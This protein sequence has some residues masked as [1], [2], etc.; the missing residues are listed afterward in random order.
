MGNFRYFLSI[1]IYIERSIDRIG[2]QVT[3]TT[4]L[5]PMD[6]HEWPQRHAPT[7]L[8]AVWNNC[9]PVGQPYRLPHTE[10]LKHSIVFFVF[11]LFI[12]FLLVNYIF[13]HHILRIYHIL[14]KLCHFPHSHIPYFHVF[15]RKAGI[16]FK[17]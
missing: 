15:D 10:L 8:F 7:A 11:S 1:S 5:R 2:R 6:F 13:L 17:S 16:A 12:L 9:R 14:H 3:P 4:P